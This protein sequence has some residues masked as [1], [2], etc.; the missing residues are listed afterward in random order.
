MSSKAQTCCGQPVLPLVFLSLLLAVF[1]KT[2]FCWKQGKIRCMLLLSRNTTFMPL[3]TTSLRHSRLLFGLLWCGGL[4]LLLLNYYENY[5]I[6]TVFYNASLEQV[7][8]SNRVSI[9]PV[10]WSRMSRYY[11][12]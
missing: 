10:L 9:K 1:F 12:P 11:R 7:S 2:S 5:N 3:I 8:F 4:K 6:F